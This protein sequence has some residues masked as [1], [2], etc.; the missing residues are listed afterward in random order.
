MSFRYASAS[1]LTQVQK[2][3]IPISTLLRSLRSRCHRSRLQHVAFGNGN[4]CL[5]AK[6]D[7]F[8]AAVWDAILKVQSLG[9]RAETLCSLQIASSIITLMP[10]PDGSR[11]STLGLWSRAVK[12]MKQERLPRLLNA[13]RRAFRRAVPPTILSEIRNLRAAKTDRAGVQYCDF[14]RP[15][16]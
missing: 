9:F 3:T 12:S 16:A 10:S 11:L 2:S 7:A 13:L 6:H 14:Q 8:A 1:P 5:T 4:A 15:D